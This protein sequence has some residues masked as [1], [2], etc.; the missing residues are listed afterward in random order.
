MSI[1]DPFLVLLVVFWSGQFAD[2]QEGL[3]LVWWYMYIRNLAINRMVICVFHWQLCYWNT[4]TMVLWKSKHQRA[5]WALFWV[6]PHLTMKECSCHVHSDLMPLK[7]KIGQMTYNW[8]TS[9]FKVESLQHTTPIH[10][11]NFDPIQEFGP[12]VG[13][14][15]SFVSG[16]SFTR[17]RYVHV[18]V[19]KTNCTW[20]AEFNVALLSVS[21]SPPIN[22]LYVHHRGAMHYTR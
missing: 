5:G 18:H 20:W 15:H 4:Y 21:E 1:L 16:C 11:V 12:E 14:G 6:F 8:T 13:G 9:G 2:G 7:E 19:P 22:R 10:W 17:L 3:Q